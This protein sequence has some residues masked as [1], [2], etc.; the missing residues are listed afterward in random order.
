MVMERV[1]VW[2]AV[3]VTVRTMAAALTVEA[4]V[5][6]SGMAAETAEAAEAAEEAEAE[7]E[8]EAAE[9]AEATAGAAAAMTEVL[10]AQALGS[11]AVREE[12]EFEELSEDAGF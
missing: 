8:A 1:L 7:A 11:R 5:A 10:G 2:P 12:L 4:T 3:T 6:E 9:A